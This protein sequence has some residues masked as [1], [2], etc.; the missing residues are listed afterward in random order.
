MRLQTS[1][2]AFSFRNS[3]LCFQVGGR[4]CSEAEAW[5]KLG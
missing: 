2:G 1:G 4:F 5:V 3:S